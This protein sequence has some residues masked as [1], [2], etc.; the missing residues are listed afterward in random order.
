[1]HQQLSLFASCSFFRVPF[2]IL[3]KSSLSCHVGCSQI[4]RRITFSLPPRLIEK[5]QLF[6]SVHLKHFLPYPLLVP[7]SMS[8]LRSFPF[9][10]FEPPA[11][12]TFTILPCRSHE[13]GQEHY[14]GSSFFYCLRRFSLLECLGLLFLLGLSL[15]SSSCVSD[16][17]SKPSLPKARFYIRSS[18]II[19]STT[20]DP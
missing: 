13:G 4:S 16:L 6:W 10:F 1:L 2:F 11:L 5:S 19:S 7:W 3:F 17:S 20:S 18:F 8:T 14:S 12:E 9:C 15:F